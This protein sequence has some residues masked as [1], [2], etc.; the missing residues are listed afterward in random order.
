MYKILLCLVI[1]FFTHLYICC[2]INVPNI[3][4]T[5]LKCIMYVCVLMCFH[6]EM[7]G[8]FLEILDLMFIVLVWLQHK[9]EQI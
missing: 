1:L 8:L 7:Y 6:V 3:Y 5:E 4:N 9:L 2:I